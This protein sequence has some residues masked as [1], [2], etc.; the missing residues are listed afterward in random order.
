MSTIDANLDTHD[1]V[2]DG[3]RPE[4]LMADLRLVLADAEALLQATAAEGGMKLEEVR[5]RILA[6][7]RQGNAHLAAMQ[8]S[9]GVHT[10][11]AAKATDDY[12]QAH[13]WPAI[14]VAGGAGLLL[15]LL[16]RG[17]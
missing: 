11:A 3:R 14:G 2:A 12:V 9:L 5:D 10:R 17:R 8:K 4:Q 7:L 15:G 13:P 6:S 1:S 16:L